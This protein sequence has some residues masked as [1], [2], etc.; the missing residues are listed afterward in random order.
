MKIRLNNFVQSV[1]GKSGKLVAVDRNMVSRNGKIIDGYLRGNPRKGTKNW[2]QINQANAFSLA[3]AGYKQ[4]KLNLL[5]W[6]TWLSK[7]DELSILYAENITARSLYLSYVL[8]VYNNT[9][10]PYINPTTMN[11]A[12]SIFN[13]RR[14]I[15]WD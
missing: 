1:S 10:T 12:D 3:N 13:D 14:L 5:N 9:L 4:L 15:T 8:K 6:V 7:A 2:L 11:N